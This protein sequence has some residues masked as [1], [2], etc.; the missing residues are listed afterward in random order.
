MFRNYWNA[1]SLI[2]HDVG[3]LFRHFI[4]W[5]LSKLAILISSALLSLVLAIPFIAIAWFIV[6]AAVGSLGATGIMELVSGEAISAESLQTLLGNTWAIIG[7]IACIAAIV[8]ITVI[9]FSYGYFLL[10]RVYQSY[11]NGAP[12][13]FS[14]NLYWKRAYLQKF[15]GVFGWSALYMMI[16]VVLGVLY[17]YLI[18]SLRAGWI[19]SPET[20]SVHSMIFGLLGVIGIVATLG[21]F[22]YFIVRTMMSNMLLLEWTPSSKAATARSFVTDSFALTKGRILEILRLLLP[23]IFIIGVIGWLLEFTQNERNISTLVE[24]ANK[25]AAA[26][27]EIFINDQEYVKT[28]LAPLSKIGEE[29]YYNLLKI[30]KNY[31]PN[32]SSM[33]KDYLRAV[34]PFVLAGGSLDQPSDYAWSIGGVLLSFLV[35]EGVMLMVYFSIFHI[36]RAT[37]AKKEKLTRPLATK[38]SA[39]QENTALNSSK[40]ATDKKQESK[41]PAK[42]PPTKTTEKSPV[43]K[44]TSKKSAKATTPP[45]SSA[46]SSTS[47]SKAKG[48]K[49]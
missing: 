45:K 47:T 17:F 13:S 26:N 39:A 3:L 42:K 7:L 9:I 46:K 22:V 32:T 44:A 12:M 38:A 36:L 19:L 48:K 33:G 40:K 8:G 41:T 4:H 30:S 15:A 23:A 20:N 49:A 34:Y 16:P 2:A 37:P 28:T 25:V 1:L 24:R 21:G 31:T 35:I 11:T 18:I 27:P 14:Q 43:K 10:L 29:G 6:S 5:N